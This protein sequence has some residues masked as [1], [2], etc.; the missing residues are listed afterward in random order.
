ML[1]YIHIPFCESKCPYCAFGSVTNGLNFIDDYFQALI[2]DF[3]YQRL[4]FGVKENQIKSVFIGGGTPSV[5]GAKFYKTLFEKISPFLSNKAE[6]TTEANPNSATFA[7]LNEMKNIGVNRVSFGAQSF[8]EDKLKFLGRAHDA[9]QIHLSVQNAKKAGFKNINLD[10]IYAT[11]FDT[12]N[13]LKKE[14]ENIARI[15]ISHLSAYSLTLEEKTPFFGKKGYQKESPV[16]AKFLFEEIEKL[17]LKQYEISNFGQ[18]CKHNLGYWQGKNYLAIGA[19]AI[20]FW[21]NFRFY[22][23]SNLKDYLKDPKNKKIE[24]LSNNDLLLEKLFLGARSIV[25]ID[26]KILNKAQ[27][28]RAEILVESKKMEFKNERF[29]NK[30]FLLA[31][32]ISLFI[33]G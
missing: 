9:N 10:L 13:R 25:G 19:Y 16:V 18:I 15:D 26:K 14:I 24:N 31:D 12:K 33:N 30:N 22:N 8:F 6:I 32:E 20:G 4:K 21:Q 11:K 27:I 17:G 28:N 7:W 2:K 23:S 29:F 1:L 5:V 3:A